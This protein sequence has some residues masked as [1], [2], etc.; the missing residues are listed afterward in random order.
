MLALIWLCYLYPETRSLRKSIYQWVVIFSGRMEKANS[1]TI[2]VF[3]HQARPALSFL[4]I[5]VCPETVMTFVPNFSAG[6]IGQTHLKSIQRSTDAISFPRGFC[7]PALVSGRR[8]SGPTDAR[9]CSS[10]PSVSRRARLTPPAVA[11]PEHGGGRGGGGGGQ[12]RVPEQP[13]AT[14]LVSSA[15]HNRTRRVISS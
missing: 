12:A 1:H 5:T 15:N 2:K 8:H 11:P 6:I 14:Q 4:I 3:I 13:P 7:F 9:P 10:P